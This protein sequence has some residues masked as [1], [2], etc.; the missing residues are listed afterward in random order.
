MHEV[1]A[2]V[3]MLVHSSF[4]VVSAANVNYL[5]IDIGDSINAANFVPITDKVKSLTIEWHTRYFLLLLV[6]DSY[7]IFLLS[8]QLSHQGF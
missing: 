4:E 7:G 5:L 1:I 8:V 3:L 2:I 6:V